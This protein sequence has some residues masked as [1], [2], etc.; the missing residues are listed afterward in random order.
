[1][2]NLLIL[3]V[4]L[5]YSSVFAKFEIR[6]GGYKIKNLTMIMD[7]QKTDLLQEMKKG[8]AEMQSMAKLMP[9]SSHLMKF[10]PTEICVPKK[11]DNKD[12]KDPCQ[13]KI[14]Y[15]STNLMKGTFDCKESKGKVVL[16][17]T[18]KNTIT[19]H[20]KWTNIK[21]AKST[22]SET[23]SSMDWISSKCKPNALNFF[24]SFNSGK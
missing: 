14:V 6:P 9:N 5:S 10:N 21:N 16:K 23:I 4:L 13:M 2:T 12:K 19:S 11:F 18:N 15:E 22:Q 3:V 8:Y 20:T 1:M 17:I 7:G 24:D